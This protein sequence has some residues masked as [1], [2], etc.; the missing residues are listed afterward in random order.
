[1]TR[2][3]TFVIFLETTALF[4]LQRASRFVLRSS[5]Y[6]KQVSLA[7]YLEREDCKLQR[8]SPGRLWVSYPQAFL[9]HAIIRST[10]P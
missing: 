1:M 3:L 5:R 6:I 10:F 9:L 4:L 8:H 7:Q 2:L